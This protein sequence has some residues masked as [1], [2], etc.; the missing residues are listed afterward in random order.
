MDRFSYNLNFIRVQSHALAW[1]NLL[2]LARRASSS[3]P[4]PFS[5]AHSTPMAL[6]SD[7]LIDM[8]AFLTLEFSDNIE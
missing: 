7:F 6:P 5:L 2:A 3:F 8:F 4:L 1:I